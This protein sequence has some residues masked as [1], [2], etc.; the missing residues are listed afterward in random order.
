MLYRPFADHLDEVAP[1]DLARLKNV[2]EGWYVEYKQKVIGN[3]ELAKSLS[4]VC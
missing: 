3:R 2:H 1:E 4:L